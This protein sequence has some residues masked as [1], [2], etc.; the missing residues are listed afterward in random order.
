MAQARDA[1][2]RQNLAA[3]T[4]RA[5]RNARTGDDTPAPD[6]LRAWLRKLTGR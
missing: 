4:A 2:R 1:E 3:A 5:E 6:G